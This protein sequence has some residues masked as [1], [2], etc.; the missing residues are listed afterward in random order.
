MLRSVNCKSSLAQTRRALLS[1]TSAIRMSSTKAQAAAED[2]VIFENVNNTKIVTLNRPSKLNSLNWSMI[3]QLHPR[4]AEYAKSDITQLIIQRANGRAFCAGGDVA[5]CAQYNAEG[6]TDGSTALFQQEYSLNYLLSTYTKPIVSLTDGITMGGGVGLAIHTPFRVA[7]ENTRTAM[8]EMD[9]GFSPDVGT[10]FAL[11]KQVPASFG[12][13]M[14]LTGESIFGLDNYFIGLSTHYIPSHRLAEVTKALTDANLATEHS[15]D[16]YTIVNNI[17]ESFTDP[18]PADYKF[19]HSKENLA[20]I[21]SIFHEEATIESIL[22]DLKEEGSPFALA[23]YETLSKKSPLSMK[24]ALALLQRGLHSDIK[25]CL[26]RELSA[27]EQFMKDSDFNEGVTSKLIT[28]SKELPNWKNKTPQEVTTKDILK[29]FKPSANFKLDTHSNT[30]FNQYPYNFGLPKEDEVKTLIDKQ[31]SREQVLE[32]FNNHKVYK[33]KA[34]LNQYLN[35]VI[36][37][38]GEYTP[39][40]T[41]GWKL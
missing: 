38:K 9:I 40:G 26:Q 2:E 12:W 1:T 7:T 36:S 32:F 39:E 34:G 15:A 24:V 19:K 23:T 37:A 14:A 27:A 13:Y 35:Y 25:S 22:N 10:T 30:T 17:L 20:L 5:S 11:N 29:F 33:N 18:L 3:T 4:L 16:S 28:K 8:P 41:L 6:R 21:D 31:F